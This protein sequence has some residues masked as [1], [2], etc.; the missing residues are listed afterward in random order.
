MV[1]TSCRYCVFTAGEEGLVRAAVHDF[2]IVNQDGRTLALVSKV[3]DHQP[4]YRRPEWIDIQQIEGMAPNKSEIDKV[5]NHLL[6]VKG[7]A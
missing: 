5:W 4:K 6:H 1:N 3:Y 7:E 2:R